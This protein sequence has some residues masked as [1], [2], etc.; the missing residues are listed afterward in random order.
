MPSET[1][2]LTLEGTPHLLTPRCKMFTQLEID[3]FRSV[4]V[5]LCPLAVLIGPRVHTRRSLIQR[6]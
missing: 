2:T 1:D 3:D 5:E 4:K 6:K